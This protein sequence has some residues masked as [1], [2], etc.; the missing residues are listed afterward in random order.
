M[1]KFDASTRL[2]ST[3]TCLPI[4]ALVRATAALDP[5]PPQPNIPTHFVCRILVVYFTFRSK[6]LLMD[7]PV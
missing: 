2:K 4:P 5:K 3:K 1:F 7:A 6:M